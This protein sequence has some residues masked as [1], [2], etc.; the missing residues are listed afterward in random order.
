MRGNPGKHNVRPFPMKVLFPVS[1]IVLLSF[2]GGLVR[3]DEGVIVS[4][5]PATPLILEDCIQIGFSNQASLKAANATLRAA[6][7][8]H[9]ALQNLGLAGLFSKEVPIRRRQ[10]CL[11]I[12]IAAA[13]VNQ[14]EWET[15]Y[16]V[17]RTYFS[18]IYARK[19]EKLLTEVYEKLKI[20]EETVEAAV[21][22]GNP[23]F[24]QIEV[25]KLNINAELV[26]TRLIEAKRGSERA[27]AAL[28]EAMGLGCDYPLSLAT[29]D[30]PGLMDNL[31]KQELISLALTQR[32]EMI[33]AVA[34]AEIVE[35]EV[36]AQQ[37]IRSLTARTFAAGS[38]VHSRPIP[39]GVSNKDYRPGAIG[40]EMPTLVAGKKPDRVRRVRALSGRAHAV[41]EKTRGLITLEA[42][43]SYLKWAEAAEKAKTLKNIAKKTTGVVEKT[44]ASYNLN[45]AGI[46]AL[47]QAQ[48]MDEKVQAQYNEA[49]F[50][51]AIALAALE[52]ITAGGF[53]PNYRTQAIPNNR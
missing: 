31:N 2:A 52:R 13:R 40:I 17:T 20:F 1:L 23:K 38:D 39:Q 36:C 21:K 35:L 19:Q 45:R 8:Q 28:R 47:L 24:T 30:L 18:F 6:R 11:G 16:A 27:L 37:A 33:Q 48:G 53:V 25:D 49:L 14:T 29:T 15:R 44:W 50:Y 10:S 46:D 42:E 51:H 22:A 43:D 12:T 3:A 34:A 4:E 5:Q 41:V 9:Q 26:K 32:G 7:A